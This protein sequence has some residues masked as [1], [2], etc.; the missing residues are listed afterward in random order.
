MGLHL[1]LLGFMALMVVAL[2][3]AVAL[4]QVRLSELREQVRRGSE[5]LDN[6]RRFSTSV[7]KDLAAMESALRAERLQHQRIRHKFWVLQAL[8]PE[9]QPPAIA[10]TRAAR[11][12]DSDNSQA[13]PPRCT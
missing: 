12:T 6:Q 1:M 9:T 4:L 13:D 10:G 3:F 7:M 2:G 11:R 8:V 5:A